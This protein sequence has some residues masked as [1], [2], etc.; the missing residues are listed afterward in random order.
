MVAGLVAMGLLPIAAGCRSDG[1][2]ARVDVL[3]EI[4]RADIKPA[5]HPP[6]TVLVVDG[7]VGDDVRRSLRMR[8]PARVTIHTRVPPRAVLTSAIAMADLDDVPADAGVLVQIGIS[9]GRVYESLFE[10]TM[11]ARDARAWRPLRV[12]LRR[13]GGW[14]WSLFYR[15]SAIAWAITFNAY[16]TGAAADDVA[17]LWASPVIAEVP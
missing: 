11:L 5:D 10:R 6:N 15:P 4:P 13:Y 17:A 7:R 14:Q 16:A 8:V 1:G 2:P 12:D 9:D 3:Q